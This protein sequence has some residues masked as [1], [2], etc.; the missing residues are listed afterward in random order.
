MMK[1]QLSVLAVLLGMAGTGL[2]VAAPGAAAAST[3]CLVAQGSH[4]WGNLQSA[5]NAAPA[6]SDLVIY[7]TCTGDTTITKNLSLIED[8]F[9]LT[10]AVLNGGGQGSVLTIGPGATVSV[11]YLIVSGGAGTSVNGVVEGGGIVNHG[12]LALNDDTITGNT[13]YTTANG[14]GEGGGVYNDG[15]LTLGPRTIVTGN[16]AGFEGGGV[17]NGGTLTLNDGSSI[18][19]NTSQWT[20]GGVYSTGP[21]TMNG[22]STIT[23]NTADIEPSGGG[24]IYTTYGYPTGATTANVYGNNPN[25]LSIG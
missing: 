17:Y 20:G 13:A 2:A 16:T 11:N 5:V 6:G 25:Q 19:H 1:R 23:D 12:T 9:A 14:V 21:L 24:G 8:I 7:G 4:E 18:S 3:T 10:P 15:T 22:S